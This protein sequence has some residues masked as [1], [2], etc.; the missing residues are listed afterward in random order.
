MAWAVLE[1]DL[2]QL[3]GISAILTA[4]MG[5]QFL[6]QLWPHS[7]RLPSYG[8]CFNAQT[9]VCPRSLRLT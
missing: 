1:Q 2:A 8:V 5:L 6:E 7:A 4:L 3:A 9:S